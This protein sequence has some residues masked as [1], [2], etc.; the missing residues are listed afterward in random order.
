MK[1]LKVNSTDFFDNV[2]FQAL[3]NRLEEITLSSQRKWGIMTVAQMLHHLNVA[4]GSGLGYFTLEDKSTFM[5]RGIIKCMILDVLKRFPVNAETPRTLK[6]NGD[7]NFDTE[8][9]LLLEILYKAFETKTDATW[10][11]HT[12]FGKITRKQCGKLIMI[13]CNHHFQQFGG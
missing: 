10:Q 13:H 9:K 4:I 5:S 6:V 1:Y 8:K 12:Y 3:V 11:V 2:N 7:F